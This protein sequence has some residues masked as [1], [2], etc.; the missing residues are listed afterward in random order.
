MTDLYIERSVQDYF[1]KFCE[2][3]VSREELETHLST[4]NTEIKVATLEVE[5]LDG[6]WDICDGNFE[7]QS[8]TL[9]IEVPRQD[10]LTQTKNTP[11][12]RWRLS[13]LHSTTCLAHSAY[14]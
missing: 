2:S 14:L 9:S 12:P 13:K 8:S 5:F 10:L 6:S 1:I 3:K 11:F 7:Q 4:K